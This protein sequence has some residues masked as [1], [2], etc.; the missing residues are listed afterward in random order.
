M[1]IKQIGIDLGTV[2]LAFGSI[3]RAHIILQGLQSGNFA[4][5]RI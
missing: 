5:E 1:L 2:N 4:G 3:D